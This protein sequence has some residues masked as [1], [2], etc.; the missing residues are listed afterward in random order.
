MSTVS[1]KP[2]PKEFR[3][4]VVRVARSR[5]P[6]VG[7]DQIAKDFGR[8]KGTISRIANSVGHDFERSATKKASEAQRQYAKAGRVAIIEAGLA[9]AEQLLQNITIVKDL[10]PWSMAVAVLIDKRRQE[11]DVDGKRRGMIRQY[12][13]GEFNRPDP[14]EP[15][16][17]S[18]HPGSDGAA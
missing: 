18:E 8:S 5:E 9:K 13:D 7:L 6:G 15:E 2:Y 4:D 10:Q 17:E 1:K 3:D 11:D 12:L 14:D 16:A